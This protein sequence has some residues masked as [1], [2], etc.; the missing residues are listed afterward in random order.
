VSVNDVMDLNH[1][2]SIDGNLKQYHPSP[3]SGHK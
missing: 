2:T 1:G 3:L